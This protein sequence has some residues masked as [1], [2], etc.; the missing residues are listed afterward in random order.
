MS[1]Q[2][3]KRQRIYDFLNAETYSNF[4]C[5]LYT[6][7]IFF[8][9]YGRKAFLKKRRSGELNKERKEILFICSSYRYLVGHHSINKKAC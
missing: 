5:L 6:K 4:L 8:F 2:E 9:F 1:V 3:K 7:Q